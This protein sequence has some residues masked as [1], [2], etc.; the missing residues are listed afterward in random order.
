M[1]E[2]FLYKIIRPIVT[3]LFK[4]FY[5]P[6]IIGRE[7]LVSDAKM[8]LVGN[9]TSNLDC[10]LVMSITKRPI[11]FLAKIELFKGIKGL[12]F[13]NMGLIPVDRSKHN[14]EA[15][16]TSE[17]YLKDGKVVLL[18]P[19]GT[20]GRGKLLPFKLGACKIA[21]N[22]NT[23]ITPFVI[24]GKYKMFKNDLSIEIL[25]PIKISDDIENSNNKLRNLIKKRLEDK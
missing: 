9:H 20:L 25:K 5:R 12:L 14:P 2:S 11:H 10:V 23:L 22:T 4:I 13:R 15:I 19:E 17:E 8:L 1:K 24:K 3:F 21:N 6:K 16:S 18:F 7:N